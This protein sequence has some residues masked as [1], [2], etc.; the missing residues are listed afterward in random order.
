MCTPAATP[1]HFK[2]LLSKYRWALALMLWL[3]RFGRRRRMPKIYIYV[4]CNNIVYIYL[5][6]LQI[7]K[8]H[9]YVVG[10]VN[11]HSTKCCGKCFHSS[12]HSG[13]CISCLPSM[14]LSSIEV[15]SVC[16]NCHHATV[17]FLCRISLGVPQPTTGRDA[18]LSSLNSLKDSGW[19]R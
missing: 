7:Y 2:L 14:F 12:L 15:R 18:F 16:A 1:Q 3:L 8:L 6:I 9:N 4:V 5:Y 11:L 10:N 17:W 19:I 13:K